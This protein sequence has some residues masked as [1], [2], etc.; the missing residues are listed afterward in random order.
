MKKKNSQ[1]KFVWKFYYPTHGLFVICLLLVMFCVATS[2]APENNGF[3]GSIWHN[4]NA[5]Y[6]SYFLAKEKIKEVEKEM[7]KNRQDDY[8]QLLDIILPLDSVKGN[9]YKTSTEFAIQKASISITKH[10]YSRWTDDN[11]LLV[12]KARLYQAD[13]RN[14]LETFKYVN[15]QSTDERTRHKAMIGLLHTFIQMKEYDKARTTIG[16]IRKEKLDRENTTDFYLTRAQLYKELEDYSKTAAAIKLALPLMKRGEEK[17]RI[18]FIAGQL[19]EL[20]GRAKDSYRNYKAV[21]R[22][23]PS[24]ELDFNTRLNL[25]E[26]YEVKNEKDARKLKAMFT[27]MLKD[28]KNK[29]NKD[30][31]YYQMGLYEY[32]NKNYTKA[33]DYLKLA[34]QNGKNNQ[35][36]KS[37]VFLKLGEIYYENLQQYEQSAKYY[38]STML[39]LPRE[40][41]NYKQANKRQQVLKNFADQVTIIRT[42]DSLQ[43]LA[44]MDE[45]SLNQLLDSVIEKEEEK[46]R[47]EK[48]AQEKQEELLNDTSPFAPRIA[49]RKTN[50]ATDDKFYFYNQTAIA[51]GQT[52]FKSK[53]G[54][55]PLEDN[56]RRSSKGASASN[57]TPDEEKPDPTSIA[58]QTKAQREQAKIDARKKARK[59]Q[60]LATIPFSEDARGASDKKIEAALYKLGK[61]YNLDLQEP[62]NAIKTFDEL[63]KRFP[64]TEY[65]AEVLYGLFVLYKNAGKTAEMEVVKERLVLKYPESEYARLAQNPNYTQD[66]NIQDQQLEGMYADA[67]SLYEAAQYDQATQIIESAIKDYPLSR[68]TEKFRLLQIYLIGK[69]QEMP[70]YRLA[71]QNFINDFPKSKNISQVRNLLEASRK[72]EEKPTDQPVNKSS[73]K[74]LKGR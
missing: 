10:K 33:I 37:Y 30:Q 29:D 23:N 72:Y 12:G 26:N 70:N 13:Y 46:K 19:Y 16:Y 44:K 1:Q 59:Q 50:N 36:R 15:T 68:L 6:N 60:M 17:A 21:L 64:A 32:R 24:F 51:R 66:G 39:S 9:A 28:E 65:G 4:T 63:M 8:S 2:C 18:H 43:T 31:I 57:N 74:K 49:E 27:R 42:E 20:T 35:V 7:F 53:W 45:K 40:Y 11:Y 22:N 58:Q 55:R 67:Y 14:A 52:E 54:N 3:V 69:T 25:I 48:E 47:K 61:I 71:L 41:K 62:E 34:T 5:H 73:D 38:D 56:W